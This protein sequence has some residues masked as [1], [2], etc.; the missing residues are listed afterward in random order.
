MPFARY[1]SVDDMPFEL[2]P[3][4][5]GAPA[6]RAHQPHTAAKQALDGRHA[7]LG[8]GALRDHVCLAQGEEDDAAHDFSTRFS[9]LS[10]VVYDASKRVGHRRCAR[11]QAM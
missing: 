11:A 2:L 6:A 9:A 7:D 5:R 4:G 10:M 1:R 8:P 3:D